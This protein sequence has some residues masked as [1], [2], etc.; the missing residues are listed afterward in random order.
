MD[1]KRTAQE[2]QQMKNM[3]HGI[4]G[5]DEIETLR[6]R[7]KDLEASTGS[8]RVIELQERVYLLEDKIAAL[9]AGQGEPVGY[10]R[11][12][13]LGTL[14][15]PGHTV[16]DAEPQAEDDIALC[17]CN[18]T[19]PIDAHCYQCIG[20]IDANGDIYPG[21]PEAGTQVFAAASKHT[22]GTK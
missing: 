17:V 19:L 2:V 14:S 13:A 9:K 6:Q 3:A 11:A 12:Y 8:K 21:T 1:N 16:I 22:K 5:N 18:T 10:V 4:S 20:V 15:K 7:V